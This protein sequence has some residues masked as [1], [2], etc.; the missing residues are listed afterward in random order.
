MPNLS[1]SSGA[2]LGRGFVIPTPGT[3]ATATLGGAFVRYLGQ[4]YQAFFG[5]RERQPPELRG[6][7]ERVSTALQR[8]HGANA[9]AVLACFASPTLGT[10]LQ[11]AGLRDEMEPFRERIDAALGEEWPRFRHPRRPEFLQT[12]PH[13]HGTSGFFVARLLV[14]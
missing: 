8:A 3:A 14:P 12:L 1:T 5:L 11:C 2:A 10:P 9:K 7:F 4:A 13:V 6:A